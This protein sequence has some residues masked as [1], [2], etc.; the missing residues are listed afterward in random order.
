MLNITVNF[1]IPVVPNLE[2]RIS[3]CC[4]VNVH[5]DFLYINRYNSTFQ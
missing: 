3:K 4:V 1:L 5:L 2:L